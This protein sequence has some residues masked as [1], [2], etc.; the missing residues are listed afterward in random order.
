M[1]RGAVMIAISLALSGACTEHLVLPADKPDGGSGGAV[2]SGGASA[3]G[4]GGAG[5]SGGAPSGSGGRWSGAGGS[6]ATG[7]SFGSGGK[8]GSGGSG[9]GM[10]NPCDGGRSLTRLSFEI[11]RAQ[12][13][14]AVGRNYSMQTPFGNGGGSRLTAVQEAIRTVVMEKDEAVNFAYLDFPS[15]GTCSNGA[16]CCIGSSVVYPSPNAWFPIDQVSNDCTPLPQQPGCTSSSNARPIAD[17]MKRLVA[18]MNPVLTGFNERRVILMV[19]GSPGCSSEDAAMSCENAIAKIA[20]LRQN[21]VSVHVLPIGA[22]P[23]AVPDCLKRIASGD[24]GGKY[25][26]S[27][28]S[29]LTWSLVS[30]VEPAAQRACEIVLTSFPSD[31]KASISLEI[32]NK[33]VSPDPVDGWSFSSPAQ[34]TIVVRGDACRRDLQH[35]TNEQVRL[36]ACQ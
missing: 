19:D 27:N 11:R 14:L 9:S 8:S 32:K 7:G 26:A 21:N 1:R 2:G 23:D 6:V 20:E 12:V 4:S 29:E 5:G 34:T 30:I 16:A 10:P 36:W 24:S 33:P 3:S 25:N 15:L 13:V 18:P 22:D 31:P 35:A 28:P 17:A